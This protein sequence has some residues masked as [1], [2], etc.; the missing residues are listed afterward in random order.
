VYFYAINVEANDPAPKNFAAARREIA[1]RILK[2][3]GLL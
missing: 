1:E 3:L 2:S